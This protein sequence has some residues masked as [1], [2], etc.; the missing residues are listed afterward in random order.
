MRPGPE[1]IA[2]CRAGL[3]Q[4]DEFWRG[5]NRPQEKT[6]STAGGGNNTHSDT[7]T[8]YTATDQ[9]Y[10]KVASTASNMHHQHFP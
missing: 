2:G 3:S 7:H 4:E 5:H 1:G 9:T 6:G 10:E 8:V